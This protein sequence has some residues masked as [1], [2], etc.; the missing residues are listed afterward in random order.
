MLC[1]VW[2]IFSSHE[3]HTAHTVKVKG[4]V[5]LSCVSVLVQSVK[6]E[7]EFLITLVPPYLCVFTAARVRF[8][9][10]VSAAQVYPLTA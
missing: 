3:S 9:H 4:N 2:V 7:F 1:E 10:L 5:D 6:S 8:F